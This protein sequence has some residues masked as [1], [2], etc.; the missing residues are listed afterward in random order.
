MDRQKA[1]ITLHE[2]VGSLNSDTAAQVGS[3]AASFTAVL[4]HLGNHGQHLTPP[5]DDGFLELFAVPDSR[6]PLLLAPLGSQT[7]VASNLG[8]GGGGG[9]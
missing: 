4:A 5:L 6:I 1:F 8:R 3:N 7:L 2:Y 9:S